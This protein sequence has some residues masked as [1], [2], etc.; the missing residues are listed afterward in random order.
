MDRQ[1]QRQKAKSKEDCKIRVLAIERMLSEGRRLTSTEII[2]RLDLQYDIQADRRTV[3]SDIYAIDRFMPNEI[4]TGR[5]GG[6]KKYDV[7]GAVEDGK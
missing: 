1:N 4:M 6:Y 7:M 3:Y 2:R 5:N